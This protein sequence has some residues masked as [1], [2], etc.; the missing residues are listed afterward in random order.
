MESHGD[1]PKMS[2]DV[3]EPP[4]KGSQMPPKSS[5][6]HQQHTSSRNEDKSSRPSRQSSFIN[7]AFTPLQSR[8]QLRQSYENLVALA[9]AQE[10]LQQTRKIVWR[11]RGEPAIELGSIDEVFEHAL[12]GG[13]RKS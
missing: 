8:K 5:Q 4:R 1:P 7:L 6:Q 2:L 3:D 13:T 12:R 9:N 11:D 10:T